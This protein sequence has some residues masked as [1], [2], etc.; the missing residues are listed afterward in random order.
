[1]HETFPARR[2]PVFRVPLPVTE[3]SAYDAVAGYLAIQTRHTE[4]VIHQKPES[5]MWVYYYESAKYL[6]THDDAHALAENAPILLDTTTGE[7]FVNDTAEPTENYI[8]A[9]RRLREE[10]NRN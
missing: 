7:G 8:A 1:M 3:E 5:E 6:R 2:C 4:M 10:E 9:Y